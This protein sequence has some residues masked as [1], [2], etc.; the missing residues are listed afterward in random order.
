MAIALMATAILLVLSLAS[1]H[2]DDPVPWPLGQWTSEPVSNVAGIA[3]AL[4]AELLLQLFGYAGW[5][6]P[7][8]LVLLGWEVFRRQGGRALSRTTGCALLVLSA[9]AT[10]HLVLDEGVDPA[11]RR[12][13]GWLGYSF[14]HL[15][16]RPLNRWGALVAAAA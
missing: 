2:P 5:A 7:L 11:T 13:G 10:L 12:A 8:L 6:I 15:L 1:Y 16:S 3:G 9:A 14:A 4:C